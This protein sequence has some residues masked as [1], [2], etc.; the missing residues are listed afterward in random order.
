MG[1]L[2]ELR[3]SLGLSQGELAKLAGVSRPT[4]AKAEAGERLRPLYAKAIA[5]AL[6]KAAKKKRK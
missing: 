1:E 3:R 4:V 5:D 2:S 6:D